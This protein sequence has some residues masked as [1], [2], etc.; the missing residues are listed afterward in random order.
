MHAALGDKRAAQM[1]FC[2]CDDVPVLCWLHSVRVLAVSP[3]LK[4]SLSFVCSLNETPTQCERVN[5]TCIHMS[6]QQQTSQTIC[7]VAFSIF[8][9]PLIGL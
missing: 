6:K 8:E 7:D 9:N 5:E 1:E 3:V 4:S 2:C